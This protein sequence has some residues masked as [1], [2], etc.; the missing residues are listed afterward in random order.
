[1]DDRVL[2]RWMALELNTL[3][4]GL[5]ASP[6]RLHEVASGAI[7]SLA[8]RA[9]EPLTFDREAARRLAASLPPLT[10]RLLRVPITFYVDKDADGAAYLADA[11]AIEALRAIG[12]IAESAS[13]RAGKTWLGVPLARAFAN[14]FPTLAQF[15]LV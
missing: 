13:P 4:R 14:E 12:W 2:D 10:T 3:Y 15:V 7:T 1:M 11:E 6:V 5:V 8:T 9:G